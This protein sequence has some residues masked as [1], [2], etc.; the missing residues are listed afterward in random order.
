MLCLCVCIGPLVATRRFLLLIRRSSAY[1]NS[2]F[3]LFFGFGTLLER[4]ATVMCVAN[5]DARVNFFGTGGGDLAAAGGFVDDDDTGTGASMSQKLRGGGNV[6]I[7]A[8][9]C[10]SSTSEVRTSSAPEA[11]DV[12][13]VAGCTRPSDSSKKRW[14]SASKP[15][16]STSLS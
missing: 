10:V 3:R 1:R 15:E 9:A 14:S 4:P 16:P 7:G 8:E 13:A 12:S 2:L 11:R 5:G 6:S